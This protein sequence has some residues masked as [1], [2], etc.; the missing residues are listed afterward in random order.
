MEEVQREAKACKSC[1]TFTKVNIPNI[2]EKDDYVTR[3]K[4]NNSNKASK[5]YLTR[6]VQKKIYNVEYYVTLY[7]DI[8]QR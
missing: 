8:K 6:H 4:N 5:I 7:K 1:T 2:W 3:N